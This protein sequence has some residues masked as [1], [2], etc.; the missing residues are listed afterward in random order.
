MLVP[1]GFNATKV[2]AEALEDAYPQP[3]MLTEGIANAVA[4]GV[5][6]LQDAGATIV[7]ETSSTG[8]GWST[9]AVLLAAPIEGLQRGNRLLEE[10]FGPVAVVVEYDHLD[11]AVTA[12]DGLQ[13][14]LAGSIMIGEEDPDAEAL[15]M[16]LESKV[17]RVIVNDWPT[18]VAFTW[19]QEHGGPWP[20]TSNPKTTSVGAAALDR[21]VRPI[22]YQG[23]PEW[24]LPEALRPHNPWSIPRRIS[25]VL[26]VAD[27]S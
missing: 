7:A 4:T 21:F 27:R 17:G 11:D 19:A 9:A 16:H 5:G 3:V 22:A 1:R 13:G 14:A 2:V 24:L 23:V 12:I 10:C 18:G 6:E 8:A 25:G 26:E 15:L 20:A